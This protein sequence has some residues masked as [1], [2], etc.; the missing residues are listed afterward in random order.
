[1]RETTLF[2]KKQMHRLEKF[3]HTYKLQNFE[4]LSS[5]ERKVDRNGWVDKFL[6]E[7]NILPFFQ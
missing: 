5:D 3:V 4:F 6:S 2:R 7:D 1:M